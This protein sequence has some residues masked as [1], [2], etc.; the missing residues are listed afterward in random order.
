MVI[1]L[2]GCGLLAV[3]A[4]LRVSPGLTRMPRWYS[5]LLPL[6]LWLVVINVSLPSPQ[7]YPDSPAPG[8]VLQAEQKLNGK[9]LAGVQYVIL[10]EGSS[11]TMNGLDGNR[12][13]AV[14]NQHGVPSLVL[15]LSCAGANHVERYEY[16]KELVEALRPD[17]IE[18]LRQ[19]KLVL[20]REVELGYDK[21]PLNNFL[22][23][24]STGRSLRYLGPDNLPIIFSW[25]TLRLGPL[26][27]IRKHTI[28]AEIVGCEL[29][30]LFHVGYV[31]RMQELPPTVKA[32]PFIANTTQSPTFTASGSL[33]AVEDAV[34]DK[35]QTASFSESLRWQR[36]RDRDFRDVFRGIPTS[37]CYFAFPSWFKSNADYNA[38]RR[39]QPGKE[40]FFDGTG[41]PLLE[42]LDTPSLWYDELHLQLPGAEIYSEEFAK[43]LVEKI[44][45][46]SL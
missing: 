11:L 39:Q 19:R 36:K 32:E 21:N 35:R 2:V 7:S 33:R 37:E 24:G 25:L 26:D 6:G 8:L 34:P 16:L 46:K 14:L 17:Q 15:Q 1:P 38:W 44:Q 41:T 29:F 42:K 23:N 10:I 22:R 4:V 31:P 45:S 30:N 28:L 20:C 43:Y 9:D 12:V 3:L 27:W 13:Q 18:A 5:L 40:F